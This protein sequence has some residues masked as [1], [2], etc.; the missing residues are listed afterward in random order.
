MMG[1]SNYVIGASLLGGAEA[2]YLAGNEAA[3]DAAKDRLARQQ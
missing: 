2:Q 3:V 1:F